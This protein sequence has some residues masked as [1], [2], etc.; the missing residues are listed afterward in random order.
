MRGKTRLMLAL[1]S[2]MLLALL[3]YPVLSGE[4]TAAYLWRALGT[5]IAMVLAAHTAANLG[6]PADPG[7]VG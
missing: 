6:L 3:I 1:L 7:R 5:G 4:L 2:P